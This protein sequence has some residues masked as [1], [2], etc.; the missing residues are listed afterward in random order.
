MPLESCTTTKPPPNQATGWHHIPEP[1]FHHSKLCQGKETTL[2]FSK[3]TQ[4][5]QMIKLNF[6]AI[7]EN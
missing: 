7:Q 4:F 5:V 1:G 6:D 3:H 2:I